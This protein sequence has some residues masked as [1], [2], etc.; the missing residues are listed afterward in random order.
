MFDSTI[1]DIP[2]PLTA[3][4]CSIQL[5]QVITQYN[6]AELDQVLEATERLD[7]HLTAAVVSNDILFLGKVCVEDPSAALTLYMLKQRN[8]F[9]SRPF[10][11]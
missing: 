7:A 11:K 9:L 10:G 5:L 8:K 4:I 6:D 1:P 3:L 2:L